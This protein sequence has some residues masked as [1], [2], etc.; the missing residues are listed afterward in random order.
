M[1]MRYCFVIRLEAPPFKGAMAIGE[2]PNKLNYCAIPIAC[3]S[4]KQQQLT[5]MLFGKY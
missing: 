3:F 2:V 4:K 1:A 5:R